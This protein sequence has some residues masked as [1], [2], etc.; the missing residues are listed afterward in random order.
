MFEA[1]SDFIL[2][3]FFLEKSVSV[4]KTIENMKSAFQKL[5]TKLQLH[6]H[7]VRDFKPN[8]TFE[9]ERGDYL[10]KTAQNGD[11]LEA[12]L[13]LRFE[14]FHREF[15]EVEQEHGIDIDKL[16]FICDHLMIID[17]R[18]ES[19][20][21]GTYRLNCTKFTSEYYSAGE[22][23]LGTL[24]D[25]EGVKLELGRACIEKDFR[26]GVV[27]TLLWRA[28]AQY[29][30]STESTILFGCASVKTMDL[31]ETASVYKYL[32]KRGHIDLSKGVH[33]TKKFLFPE[34]SEAIRNLVLTEDQ[35]KKIEEEIPALFKSYL[36]MN[37][38][39]LGEPARD[40]DFSC[41]DFLTVLKVSDLNP[42]FM[43][44]YKV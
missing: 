44:K 3:D 31:I 41:V 1:A 35:E 5:D 30:I 24:L 27:I 21:I 39:V 32:E 22:F 20:V 23:N 8:I 10:V 13:R 33:P 4:R 11:E 14:V 9:F 25:G 42:L 28:I 12:C 37:A 6:R 34:L 19:K 2:R 26:N 7:K 36:R 16:D 17:R 15:M 43:K 18:S 29:L 40:E 38:K